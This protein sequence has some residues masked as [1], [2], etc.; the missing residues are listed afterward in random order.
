MIQSI[1]ILIL[2]EFVTLVFP[3]YAGESLPFITYECIMV[4]IGVSIVF[5]GTAP[6]SGEFIVKLELPFV[7]KC[8]LI[9][10]PIL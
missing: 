5:E 1:I 7:T 6:R 2:I 4:C 10:T 3:D 9:S 8:C